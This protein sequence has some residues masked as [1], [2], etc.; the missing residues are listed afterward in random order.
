M[1]TT[2]T[3]EERIDELTANWGATKKK[4]FS[5]YGY[6]INGNLAFGTHKKDQ[7]IVRAGEERASE[8][9]KQPGIRIFDMTG[10]PMKNWFIAEE[11]AYSTDKKLLELLETGRDFAKSLPPK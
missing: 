11:P 3:L 1:V 2:M 7:L 9:L 8:L 4:M 6:M 10:R 5:G